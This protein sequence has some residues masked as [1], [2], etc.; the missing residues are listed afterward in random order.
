MT[1][2]HPPVPESGNDAEG[3]VDADRGHEPVDRVGTLRGAGV[4]GV[5][6]RRL[7][8]ILIGLILAALTVLVVVFTVVGVHRNQQD[9]RLHHDG[10]PVTFTV[11]GCLGLLGGSGSNAA[12]YSCHGS[13]TLDGRTYRVQLPGNDFHRP[14]AQVPALAVPGDPTLVSPVALARTERSS[15]GVFLVPAILLVILV[16]I[17]ALLIVRQRHRQRDD[18]TPS[19]PP[20][21]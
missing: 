18:E 3:P 6:T 17:V 16:L 9:D 12:G 15:A 1:T 4:G 14:G 5:D 2:A 10:V 8:R 20:V 11:S 21:T 19:R 7:G 13:Y